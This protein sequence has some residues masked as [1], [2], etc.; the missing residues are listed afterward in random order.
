VQVRLTGIC[1]DNPTRRQIIRVAIASAST[2]PPV[3]CQM[4]FCDNRPNLSW[5]GSWDVYQVVLDCVAHGLATNGIGNFEYLILCTYTV[6]FLINDKL[7][8]TECCYEY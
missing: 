8:L 3:L 6:K 5:L 4:S 2:V 7:L 1:T